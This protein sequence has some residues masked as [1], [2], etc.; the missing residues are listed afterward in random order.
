MLVAGTFAIADAP[1]ATTL[2][3]IRTANYFEPVPYS[4]TYAILIL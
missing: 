1:I 2:G 4:G 3:R